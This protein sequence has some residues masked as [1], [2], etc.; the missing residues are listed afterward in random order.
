MNPFLS[1]FK[2]DIQPYHEAIL[3]HPLYASI[4]AIEDLK[5][6]ME[7]H[8][9]AVWDF[10]SLL[11]ALQ[12]KCTC[13]TIPW[14][15]VGMGNIRYL[16]NEIVVGE[17]SDIAPTG[18]RLSHY[19][20]YLKAMSEVGCDATPIKTLTEQSVSLEGLRTSL[21]A[22]N[23]PSAAAR[24]VSE[25]FDIIERAEVH[26]LAAVFAYG[27]EDLVPAMFVRLVEELEK[28]SNVSMETLTYYLKRHIELDGDHHSLLA[29][30][31]V[32]DLCGNDPLKWENA[33]K[34]T[35]HSL[36][37]RRK[38]WDGIFSTIEQHA[39]LLNN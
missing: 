1:K 30:Q 21:K 16:I 29:E 6:F 36:I 7:S 24:F 5:T 35:I 25:T 39:A 11:K 34:E 27:R 10:M 31:M 3:G 12:I 13:T 2:K 22:S 33:T 20:L 18:E 38:L 14:K 28:E 8:V 37:E 4:R 26:A 15:P 23:I 32:V 17:E 19:E 9:F